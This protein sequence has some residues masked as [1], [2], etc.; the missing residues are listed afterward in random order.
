MPSNPD[1]EGIFCPFF[2]L[3][4]LGLFGAPP[5][6]PCPA[7]SPFICYHGHGQRLEGREEQGRG[8]PLA[9]GL[10]KGG[11]WAMS[12]GAPP[13][14]CAHSGSRVHTVH[15]LGASR[16]QDP[17]PRRLPVPTDLAPNWSPRPTS[18]RAP[19]EVCCGA[20]SPGPPPAGSAHG[21]APPRPQAE[22]AGPRPLSILAA[23]GAP[24]GPR[25]GLQPARP[26]QRGDPGP[27][28]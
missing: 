12:L 22:L 8:R 27:D 6:T 20:P 13:R 2:D 1:W 28:L 3:L 25:E 11:S 19:P 4:Y 15:S 5:L 10:L 16:A 18:G 26:R 9:S 14:V 7:S 21:P 17:N 24:G 23:R